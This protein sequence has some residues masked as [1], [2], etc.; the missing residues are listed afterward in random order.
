MTLT[1]LPIL[2]LSLA[3]DPETAE[4]FRAELRRVT[5][6]IGF[7]YLTGH[8]IPDGEFSRI[9]DVAQRFFALPEADKL[10]IENTNSPHFRG[11]TRTG[12]ERTQ[13]R[14]DWR[15][16]IDIGPERAPVAEPVHDFDHL[17]GP[18]QYPEALPELREATDS[19]HARLSEVGDRLLSEWALSL[20]QSADHFAS[21]FAEDPASFIKIVRYPEAESESVTQGVGE[22]R[23]GG[24]LTL[25]YPQPGTTGLQ[26]RTDDGWI[27]A[28][29]IENAFVVNI[30]K[31]LEVATNGY[32]KATVHRV[33]PTGPGEDRI[34]IPFFY[35]PALDAR[36][37]EVLLPAA[38]A[39][40]ARGVTQDERDAL[41]AVYGEN[42]FASRLRSHPN[43]AEKYY[44]D[45]IGVEA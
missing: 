1:Q 40:E 28:D 37:P 13:G 35:N 7:F 36:L 9:I 34:S 43:V 4:D 19:W 11:Y 26:V 24:T 17:T 20:G 2:D 15:E 44:P 8:G 18:N 25:L 23:D 14:V 42:A 41:H 31:L 12:G 45:L 27:D 22:H 29:P 21:A 5:H 10:A 32:L 3:D 38:L 16:Q 33:L 6:E 39:A 30:G